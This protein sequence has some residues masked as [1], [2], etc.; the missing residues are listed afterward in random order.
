[1]PQPTY[2]A[3]D[4]YISQT[5]IAP[6][7]DVALDTALAASAAAGLPNINVAPNQ[8]KLLHLFALMINARHILEVGT[9]AGYS[10]IWLARALPSAAPNGRPPATPHAPAASHPPRVV[11]L[12]LDEKHAAVARA[13]FITANVA[14]RIDLRVGPALQALPQLAAEVAANRRPRFDLTFIDADKASTPH[15][16]EHAIQLS[17]P[18]AVI[19]IDN[20]IRHGEI[21]DQSTT[22]PSTLGIRQMF[23]QL[24]TERRVSATAIQT[25]GVKGWDGLAVLVVKA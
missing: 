21:L 19:I 14:D 5:L 4:D 9:L 11:T 7:P 3:I 13:N 1:M 24:T 22:D 16:L 23:E 25:V 2:V 6:T 20:V 10:T 18:G 17:R 15:Y 8:G 12:E